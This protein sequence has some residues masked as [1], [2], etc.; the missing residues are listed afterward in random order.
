[1]ILT[2]SAWPWAAR[3]SRMLTSV[4]HEP[5]LL[6]R[7]PGSFCS[8]NRISPSC[9][10]EP[11]LNGRPAS[12]CSSCSSSSMRFS[13]SDERLAQLRRVDLDAGLL[14]A[15][16]HRDQRPLDGLVDADHVLAGEPGLELRPQLHGDVGVFGRVVARLVDRHLV[17]AHL[18]GAAAGHVGELDGVLAEIELGQ[19][20]HAVIVL[21]GVEH[22]GQQHG[23][24]DRRRP[25]CRA[26]GT[27]T[28][29]T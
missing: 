16:Q 14:H 29:R 27:R 25:R 8:S 5:F 24:V 18:L 28:C 10:G 26:G 2:G 15:E 1:M 20:V 21:A 11:T 9:L 17:E 12:L 7:P 23:V 22:E 6:R 3:S 4:A 19:L 13:N